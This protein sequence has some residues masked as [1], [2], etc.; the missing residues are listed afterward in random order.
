M[1][2]VRFVLGLHAHQPV[3]SSPEVIAEA[4]QRCYV[5]F[6]GVLNAFPQIPFASL[7]GTRIVSRTAPHRRAS[8]KGW[9]RGFPVRTKSRPESGFERVPQRIRLLPSWPPDGSM[10]TVGL[11]LTLDVETREAIL[12]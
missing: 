7:L 9:L 1:A 4:N 8:Q 3:G 11:W 12:K 5:P 10:K 2:G 6:L